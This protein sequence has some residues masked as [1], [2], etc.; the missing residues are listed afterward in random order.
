[1][2][3]NDGRDDG[4]QHYFQAASTWENTDPAEG[5]RPKRRNEIQQ[6]DPDGST[7]KDKKE[8]K[9]GD[10]SR[11]PIQQIDPEAQSSRS[12]QNMDLSMDRGS[13][14]ER[15]SVGIENFVYNAKGTVGMAY[16]KLAQ[17]RR[18]SYVREYEL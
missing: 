8:R 7:K 14:R 15:G 18:E 12:I 6:M 16:R 9:K 1:M 3:C 10:R 11:G 4:Q 2:A 13:V 17:K 5:A